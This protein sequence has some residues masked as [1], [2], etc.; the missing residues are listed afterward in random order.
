MLALLRRPLGASSGLAAGAAARSGHA[1]VRSK[2]K[3]SPRV[4]TCAG[5]GA[6]KVNKCTLQSIEYRGSPHH[7][8]YA[9]NSLIAFRTPPSMDRSPDPWPPCPPNVAVQHGRPRR[10]AAAGGGAAAPGRRGEGARAPRPLDRGLGA[11]QG[12][13]MMVS[14]L[15]SD[16]GIDRLID[17]SIDRLAVLIDL[18][19]YVTLTSPRPDPFPTIQPPTTELA[20]G[21]SPGNGAPPPRVPNCRAPLPA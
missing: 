9:S 13:V 1:C 7:A 16:G 11:D 18:R 6:S 8:G 5:G 2:L 17:R 20:R 14:V 4:W 15:G 21:S 10:R 19:M 3:P 12:M